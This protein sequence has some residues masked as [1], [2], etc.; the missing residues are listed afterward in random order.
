M[1][2]ARI[3]LPLVWLA[4]M[5]GLAEAGFDPSFTY[6]RI[7]QV[8]DQSLNVAA[9]SPIGETFTPMLHGINF[10][11]FGFANIASQPKGGTYDIALY[12]G[13]GTGGTLLATTTPTFLPPGFGTQPL[14]EVANFF[15][16]QTISLTPGTP[17]SLMIQ[18]ISGDDFGI[19]ASNTGQVGNAAILHG[20]AQTNFNLTFGEGLGPEPP[21]LVLAVMASVTGLV[22]WYWRRPADRVSAG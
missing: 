10:A 6:D 3:A 17:Y 8:V 18:K 22:H 12:Q 14:G 4:T 1:N 21:S 5:T 9:F 2:P 7:N 11:A 15:F 16:A 13:V 20:V 19:D